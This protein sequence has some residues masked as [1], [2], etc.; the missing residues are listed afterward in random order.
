MNNKKM[1]VLLFIKTPPPITGATLMNKRV[2][3]SGLLREAFNIRSICISYMKHRNE[4]G[5]WKF[6]KFFVFFNI[7]FQLLY[8]LI[9]YRPAM[10]YFQLSPHG[11]AFLRDLFFVS[12]MKIFHVR[13]VFHIRGKGITLKS[14]FAKRFYKYCFRNEYIICLSLL[15][16]SDI[17]DVYT[18]KVSIVPNGIPDSN[19]EKKDNLPT[20]TKPKLL[21]LSNLI[22]SKGVLDYIEALS[23]LCKKGVDFKG[24]IVGAEGDISEPEINQIIKNNNLQDKVHYLG[25]KYYN[26]KNRI[27]FE[28]DL[29]IFPTKMPWECFPGVI[30]EAMQ[31]GLPVISTTE[32][33]IPEIIDDG[34]TGFVV[35][36]S[37]PQQLAEK[38]EILIKN[39]QLR[40][41]MGQA[42]RKKYEEKYTLRQF[43]ENMKNVFTDV[44]NQITHKN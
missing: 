26:E 17:D 22:K 3:D 15:L 6:S 32:G 5:K 2:Y 27:L 36:K 40:Q 11:F 4:M 23:I 7:L 14:N 34:V 29:F 31:F 8:E 19:P 24:T 37:S 35:E 42:G 43:E 10:I 21:F 20:E 1:K 30:L 28:N 16:K 41:E 9:F 44:L 33:A 18:G 12:I 39:P 13:I 38:I 25:P